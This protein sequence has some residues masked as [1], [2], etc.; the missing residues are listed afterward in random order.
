MNFCRSSQ[1]VSSEF[2]KNCRNTLYNAPAKKLTHT[3]SILRNASPRSMVVELKEVEMTKEKKMTRIKEQS[4]TLL[5]SSSS[6][7]V[8]NQNCNP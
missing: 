8:D 6:N 1:D 2:A 7:F 4:Y 3:Y 5:D